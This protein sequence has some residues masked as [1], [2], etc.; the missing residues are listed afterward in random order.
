MWNINGI[1]SVLTKGALQEFL[2]KS[3]PDVLCFNEIKIG[4]EKIKQIGLHKYLPKQ[5]FQ[6]WNCSKVKLGYAGTAI[7]TKVEP[8]HV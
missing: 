5:Y 3:N 1:N 4:Q 7:L 6:F 8:I 2:D